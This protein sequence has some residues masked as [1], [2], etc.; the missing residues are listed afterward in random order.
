MGEFLGGKLMTLDN[1][2][3]EMGWTKVSEDFHVA[4]YT[5]GT[6]NKLI[7]APQYNTVDLLDDCVYNSSITGQKL[8]ADKTCSVY[9]VHYHYNDN[10]VKWMHI[11]MEWNR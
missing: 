9:S 2:A 11:S 3:K 1:A 8:L 4:T 7:F 5:D 10:S 6:P